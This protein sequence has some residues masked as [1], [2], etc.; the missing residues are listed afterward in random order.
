LRA[1]T[2]IRA[3]VERFC[4]DLVKAGVNIPGAFPAAFETV[5]KAESA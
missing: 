5:S 2:Q 3:V 1:F 4:A